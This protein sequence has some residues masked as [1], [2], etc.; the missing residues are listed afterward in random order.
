MY[1]YSIQ[2]RCQC[3]K[4]NVQTI[5][6]HETGNT[7][8]LWGVAFCCMMGQCCCIPWLFNDCLDKVHYCP[9]CGQSMLRKHAKCFDIINW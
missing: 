9:N 4:Q 5:L 1:N 7:T 8:I 6:S 2:T 3:C